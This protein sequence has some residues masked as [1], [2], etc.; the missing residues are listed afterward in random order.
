MSVRKLM[1]G[2]ITRKGDPLFWYTRHKYQ[3]R[4]KYTFFNTFFDF[5]GEMSVRFKSNDR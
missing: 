4:V 2:G 5:C 3:V 1:K